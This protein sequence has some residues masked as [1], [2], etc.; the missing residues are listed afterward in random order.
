M[1]PIDEVDKVLAAYEAL[2]KLEGKEQ[3]SMV[4]LTPQLDGLIEKIELVAEKEKPEGDF[5]FVLDFSSGVVYEN[6][7]G[8]GKDG[9]KS[10]RTSSRGGQE[11]LRSNSSN[12]SEAGTYLSQFYTSQTEDGG[13]GVDGRSAAEE[14]LIQNL[15]MGESE[16]AVPDEQKHVFWADENVRGE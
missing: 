12:S 2:V 13:A 8:N 6:L 7:A 1:N 14:S 3:A 16:E 9:R 4:G 5:D 11:S 15:E 10:S